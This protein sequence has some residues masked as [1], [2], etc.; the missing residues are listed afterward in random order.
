LYNFSI[1]N[2][3]NIFK[4]FK[5]GTFTS[6]K[7]FQFLYFFH[8]YLFVVSILNT[9]SPWSNISSTSSFKLTMNSW[10]ISLGLHF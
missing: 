6:L 5:F 3:I 8:N 9:S 7:D 10:S 2:S 1:I 4:T